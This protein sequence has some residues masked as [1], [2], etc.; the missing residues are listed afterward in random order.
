MAVAAP[1]K[2]KKEK[3]EINFLDRRSLL[4]FKNAYADFPVVSSI[5]EERLRVVT[6]TFVHRS[7]TKGK[8]ATEGRICAISRERRKFRHAPRWSIWYS[9]ARRDRRKLGGGEGSLRFQLGSP[10]EDKELPGV[11]GAVS[12]KLTIG[13][14]YGD[15]AGVLRLGQSRLTHTRHLRN[16]ARVTCER[17]RNLSKGGGS[18]GRNGHSFPVCVFTNVLHAD[19]Y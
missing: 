16:R 4:Q 3:V 9:A 8:G 2:R 11:A 12:R 5:N 6:L 18:R 15:L 7:G 14:R 17:A 1:W 10:R 13:H 19:N